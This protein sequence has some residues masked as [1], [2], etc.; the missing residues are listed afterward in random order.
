MQINCS[1]H[2]IIFDKEEVFISMNFTSAL[3]TGCSEFLGCYDWV[4]HPS[5]ISCSSCISDA[6]L[7]KQGIIC[8]CTLRI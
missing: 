1:L 5:D 4:H 8:V 2:L 7:G 3:V 6:F